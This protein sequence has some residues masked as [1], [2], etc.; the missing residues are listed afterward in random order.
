M[1]RARLGAVLVGVWGAG[2]LG[3]GLFNTDP[4]SGFPLGTPATVDYTTSGALHDAFS[5]PALAWRRL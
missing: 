2:L 5:L 4:V 3:A 1:R